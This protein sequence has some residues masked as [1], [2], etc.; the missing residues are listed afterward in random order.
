[1]STIP[2]KPY[3]WPTSQTFDEAIDR[4]TNHPLQALAKADT[5]ALQGSSLVSARWSATGSLLE[6]SNTLWLHIFVSDSKV[7]WTLQGAKPEITDD[8]IDGI[9]SPCVTLNWGGSVGAVPMN[10]SELMA[11]RMAASFKLLYVN[12]T[13]LFIYFRGHDILCFYAVCRTDTDKDMLYLFEDE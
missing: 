13:G 5:A 3:P 1:M 9:G 11:K 8:L 7:S 12:D 6:F 4:A 10:I 2:V